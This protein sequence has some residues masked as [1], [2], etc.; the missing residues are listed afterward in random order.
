M[1]HVLHVIE[2]LDRGGATR[3]ALSTAKQSSKFGPFEHSFVSLKSAHP[4]ALE[5]AREAGIQVHESPSIS[6]L[7][8]LIDDADILQIEYWNAPAI[9]QLLHTSLPPHR[10]AIWFHIAGSS[11]PQRIHQRL[12]DFADIPIACAPTPFEEHPLFKSALDSNQQPEPALVIAPADFDRIKK[13]SHKP[14]SGFNIGY[15]GTL[16]FVKMHRDFIPMS[17]NIEI[18]DSTF[19]VCGEGN[20]EELMRQATALNAE[21]RFDFR[22][23]VEDISSVLEILDVY[24]YPLCEDT[25][26]AAELNLQEVMYAGIPPIVFPH[27]GIKG[28]IQHNRTGLFVNSIEDYRRAIEY[29][30]YNPVER[31]RLGVNAAAYARAHFGSKNAARSINKVYDRLLTIPKRYH[32]WGEAPQDFAPK[33]SHKKPTT[34]AVAEL[35]IESL[36]DVNG[37]FATSMHDNDV[38]KT[39]GSRKGDRCNVLSS[40]QFGDLSIPNACPFR[41]LF[42]FVDRLIHGTAWQNAGST[43]FLYFCYFFRSFRLASTVVLSSHPQ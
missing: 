13:V 9:N 22:G 8:G 5:L 35:F 30:Y 28:L 39:I 41:P 19:I 33:L 34:P 43:L 40:I 36:G 6:Q 27:G 26:A 42:E 23:F 14:H 37:S 4:E 16:S 31:K 21:H 11:M 1:P 18:P 24:G 20:Q 29:L 25:Y 12:F 17:V 10:S 3:A 2:Y 38:A 15:I 7:D 32:T